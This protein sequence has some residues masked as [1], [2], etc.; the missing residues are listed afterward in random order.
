MEQ[1]QFFA[2]V[3][4]GSQ[5]HQLCLIDG[6]GQVLAEAAFAHSGQGLAQMLDWLTR[7]S[8]GRLERLGVAIERTH[9]A[10]VEMLLERCVAVFAI[11]PKQLDRFRDRFSPAGAKDDRLDARVLAD[12]LRTDAHCFRRLAPE[13]EQIVRLRELSRAQ[14]ELETNLRQ[15]ANRLW[16]LLSRYFPSLLELSSGA[17]EAWLWSLLELAPTPQRAARLKLPQVE[18]ILKKHRLRRLE[19]ARVLEAVHA[20]QPRLAPGASEAASAHALRLVPLL[21]LLRQ[22]LLAVEQETEELLERMKQEA[23][24]SGRPSD[25]AIMDSFKG[26][27]VKTQ[28]VLLSEASQ[29]IA[30]R[31]LRGLRAQCGAAPV[32]EQSGKHCRV[33]MR[34]ACS[35]RLRQAIH[36]CA[37]S[38]A[39]HE[40]RW[41]RIYER[42]KAKGAS[43]GRA[44]R[45]VADRL[46]ALLVVLLK[47]G[48]RFDPAYQKP[49][50]DRPLIA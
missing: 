27:G 32:T 24:E 13:T 1:E 5:Q 41:G 45:G 40:A 21:R 11:N 17:D 12:S 44:V 43:H 34:R 36:Q 26:V 8:G 29:A 28:A 46:L 23:G 2:G 50:T 30:Q 16:S 38:A 35:R 18:K 14:E 49:G 9:G 19:A 33:L 10:V 20:S 25:V 37:A 22:Q 42:L 31:D 39:Q 7:Q 47:K 15:Q 6:R 4:W 3:D 48:E